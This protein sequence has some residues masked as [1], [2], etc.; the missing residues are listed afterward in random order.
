MKKLALLICVMV[1]TSCAFHNNSTVG[2][3]FSARKTHKIVR[4]KTT[5]ADIYRMFGDPVSK[6]LDKNYNTV[7]TYEYDV[8]QMRNSFW[9][10]KENGTIHVKK[11]IVVFDKN[12]IVINYVYLNTRLH[13]SASSYY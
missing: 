12:N 13:E 6:S 2:S 3:N 4:H 10:T 1:L 8:A 5:M 7:W 11:L 9:S